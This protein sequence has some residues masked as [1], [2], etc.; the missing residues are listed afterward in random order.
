V[1]ESAGHFNR[2]DPDVKVVSL[3]DEFVAAQPNADYPMG[4]SLLEWS[5]VLTQV[6]KLDF[7]T[8]IPGHGNDPV[9]KADVAAYQKKID[10]IAKK[11]VELA[12]LTGTPAYVLDNGRIVDIAKRRRKT[13]KTA[14]MPRRK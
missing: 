10:E 12:R 7:D 4:G 1:L 11:A 6:L 8:A 13:R 5:K 2:R 14:G 9:K 3:G